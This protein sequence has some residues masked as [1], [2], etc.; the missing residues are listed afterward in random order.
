MIEQICEKCGKAIDGY[1]ATVHT[2][3]N[4]KSGHTT[5][6]CEKC[7][8]DHGMCKC[9]GCS[10]EF[11]EEFHMPR[12]DGGLFCIPC[13]REKMPECF[14]ECS[15]FKT[16]DDCRQHET[17]PAC[18][19][20]EII[21]RTSLPA[22]YFQA[23]ILDSYDESV[24]CTTSSYTEKEIVYE[25]LRGEIDKI[26]KA[27]AEEIDDCHYLGDI[28]YEEG[29]EFND[30]EE[31]WDFNKRTLSEWIETAI[32]DDGYGGPLVIIRIEANEILDKYV[33]IDIARTN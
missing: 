31:R 4:R 23:E 17:L 2:V 1:A 6:W 18:L 9:D 24:I 32:N 21:T 12:I 22:K 3:E 5:I 19:Q 33:P 20:A 11:A 8:E 30:N 16:R 27:I 10:E 14:D 13:A 7:C 26:G 25:E 29:K 28:N 15:V